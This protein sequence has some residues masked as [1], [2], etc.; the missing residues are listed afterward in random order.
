M[1]NTYLALLGLLDVVG[2]WEDK[3]LVKSAC[4]GVYA[5]NKDYPHKLG[6]KTNAFS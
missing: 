4:K 3:C 2:R 1:L 5:Y 6:I